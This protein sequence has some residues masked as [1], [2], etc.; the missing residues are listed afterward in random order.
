MQGDALQPEPTEFGQVWRTEVIYHSNKRLFC[1]FSLDINCK[2]ETSFPSIIIYPWFTIIYPLFPIIY[3]SFTHCLQIGK[4]F[5][6]YPFRSSG[7]LWGCGHSCRPST[8]HSSPSAAPV[9]HGRKLV[10]AHKIQEIEV[11]WNGGTPKWMV[12]NGKS[13]L[14]GWFRGTPILGNLQIDV[15]KTE[16]LT[17]NLTRWKIHPE[18]KVS[19]QWKQSA[20]HPKSAAH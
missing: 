15:L 4:A 19:N 1:M 11:S 17:W 10:M 14:N 20:S 2:N 8:G 6:M 5:T 18:I 3:P 12:Y 16:N 7:I 9:R 13:Y